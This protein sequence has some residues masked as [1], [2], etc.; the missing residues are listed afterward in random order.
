[1]FLVFVS[2][3]VVQCIL[4]VKH[5]H[6][7]KQLSGTTCGYYALAHAQAMQNL[8]MQK[9]LINENTV[10]KETERILKST[11]GLNGDKAFEES[12]EMLDAADFVDIKK[13]DQ[14]NNLKTRIFSLFDE[15]NRLK[16]SYLI[17][18]KE[19]NPF[20][21]ID[22]SEVDNDGYA[23][24]DIKKKDDRRLVNF[25]CNIGGNKGGHFVYIGVL[26]EKNKD[27]YIIYIDSIDR[28][29]STFRSEPV[30]AML[31]VIQNAIE[32][33]IVLVEAVNFKEPT[34]RQEVDTSV[35]Q[36]EQNHLEPITKEEEEAQFQEGIKQSLEQQAGQREQDQP[37]E[38]AL[39]T[40]I[41]NKL[42]EQEA[43]MQ[44]LKSQ[45]TK[46]QGIKKLFS[47]TKKIL[48][49]VGQTLDKQ[50]QK[51]KTELRMRQIRNDEQM[52]RSL[53]AEQPDVIQP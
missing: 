35:V 36:K 18:H 41:E 38:H 28:K 49:K 12:I 27:S 1:M 31:N 53:A 30:E 3:S 5:W 7:A 33:N 6:A 50:I 29:G 32:K 4:E 2:Q 40:T 23:L 8:F 26:K 11:F 15:N 10:K 45:S 22:S 13:L 20:F 51:I 17:E 44:E 21:I 24:L 16:N 14:N 46:K 42:Q 9:K 43:L 19:T 37:E 47:S 48:Q 34:N 25:I 39:T 52:A